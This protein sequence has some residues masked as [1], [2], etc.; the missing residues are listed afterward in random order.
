MDEIY[1]DYKDKVAFLLVYIREAHPTD[2]RQSRANVRQRILVNQPTTFDERVAVATV[3]CEKFDLRMPSVIDKLD[4]R[5]SRA[6]SAAP[7]RLYLIDV[8]GK[9]AYQGARGPKGFKPAELEQAIQEATV[10]NR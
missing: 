8:N 1:E 6:Y 4:D 3:M 10:S 9:I 2:G 7:D 5:V